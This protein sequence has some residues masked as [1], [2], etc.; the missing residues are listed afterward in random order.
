M[1]RMSEGPYQQ[2]TEKE[3][4]GRRVRLIKGQIGPATIVPRGMEMTI[5]GKRGG[6]D[7]ESDACCDRGVKTYLR[8]VDPHDLELLPLAEPMA[9][10]A[11]DPA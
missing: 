3:L 9:I 5:V 6:L 1:K 2:M 11:G 10:E 4:R 8:Q 7:L